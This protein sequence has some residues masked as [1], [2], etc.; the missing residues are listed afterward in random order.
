MITVQSSVF[1]RGVWGRGAQV[2]EGGALGLGSD[3]HHIPKWIEEFLIMIS[4]VLSQSWDLPRDHL[5]PFEEW[6]N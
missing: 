2:D 5:N 1:L 4:S 6:E 3:G